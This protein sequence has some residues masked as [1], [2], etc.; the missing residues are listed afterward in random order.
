MKTLV[1]VSLAF[2]VSIGIVTAI[3]YLSSL[4][5]SWRS[6]NYSNLNSISYGHT[7]RL[8]WQQV[9]DFY[10]LN[11]KRW[12]FEPI[13]LEGWNST[14]TTTKFLLYNTG[15][16]W[17]KY[18]FQ[19]VYDEPLKIV[20]VQLSLLDYIKF[21]INM[22]H[23]KND[24]GLAIILDTVSSDIELVRAEAQRQIEEATKSMKEIK[25]RVEQERDKY[26]AMD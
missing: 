25:D 20:R 15:D 5:S 23:P 4:I 21:R 1:I 11:P 9:K 26:V 17:S 8:T 22:N 16:K 24:E 13:I 6:F 10:S 12:K 18:A 2:I 7:T 14:T 3:M 19:E